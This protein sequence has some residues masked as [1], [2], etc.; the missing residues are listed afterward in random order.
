MANTIVETEGLKK[1]IRMDNSEH[2]RVELHMHTK[3]SQMDAMTSAKDLIK[4]Q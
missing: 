3:M 4:E 1:E 2:K